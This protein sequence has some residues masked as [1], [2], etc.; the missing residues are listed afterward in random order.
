MG[1]GWW[2]SVLGLCWNVTWNENGGV[3]IRRACV[4]LFYEFDFFSLIWPKPKLTRRSRYKIWDTSIWV[5]VDHASFDSRQCCVVGV[6]RRVLSMLFG[7]NSSRRMNTNGNC[8]ARRV[9]CHVLRRWSRLSCL[10]LLSLG[11][12]LLLKYCSYRSF[13]DILAYQFVFISL[14]LSYTPS[15]QSQRKR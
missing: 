9:H 1:L 6:D 15:L 3:L 14:I 8:S 2:R 13:N 12:S 4:S 10:G 5:F 7:G 11:E